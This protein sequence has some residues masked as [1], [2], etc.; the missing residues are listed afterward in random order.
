MRPGHEEKRGVPVGSWDAL[1]NA[2]N[3]W[4]FAPSGLKYSA[5]AGAGARRSIA[6]LVA[7]HQRS[8]Y[9]TSLRNGEVVGLLRPGIVKDTVDL[10]SDL[11]ENA[12]VDV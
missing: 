1:E 2:V 7:S 5:G 8:I 6:E 4:R 3:A 11:Y 10:D 12:S 9:E